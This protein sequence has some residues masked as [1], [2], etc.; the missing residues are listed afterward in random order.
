MIFF[1]NSEIQLY[2]LMDSDIVNDFGEQVQELVPI[3]ET[4][5][6]DIQSSSPTELNLEFGEVL[7]DV[8]V[9]YTNPLTNIS[10]EDVF[11]RVN[12][13]WFTILGGVIHTNNHL[14]ITDHTKFFIKKNRKPLHSVKSNLNEK[15]QD[16][17]YL[18]EY[19]NLDY[20]YAL[21][22]FRDK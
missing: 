9:V 17:L 5:S 19:S 8:Y 2:F 7:Q 15:I 13:D 6:A 3:T 10:G 12:D 11:V 21:D 4:L 20:D 14:G 16:Y 1:P 22:Y 18:K